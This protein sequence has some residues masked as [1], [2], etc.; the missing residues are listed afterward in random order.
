MIEPGIPAFDNLEGRVLRAGLGYPAVGRGLPGSTW[1][2]GNMFTDT[3][4]V[5][6][7]NMDDAVF[8]DTVWR[9]ED[10][11]H[12]RLRR[13]HPVMQELFY[14]NAMRRMQAIEQLTLPP[15]YTTIPNT[16]AFSRFEHMWGSALLVKQLAAQQG[17]NE[18]YTLWC[19][20]RTLNSDIKQTTGSHK[21][22]WMFQGIGGPE[23]LHDQGIE[24]YMEATG[25]TNILRKHGIEP[26]TIIFPKIA[27]WV[28]APSPDLCIDRVDY[29]LREM[30]RWNDTV[31]MLGFTASDFVLTPDL[32]LA[33]RDQQRAR[34]FSEGSLALTQ[35][36]YGE[37]THHFIEELEMLMTKL[38]YVERLAPDMWAFADHG[39]EGLVPLHEIHPHDL[40]YITDAAQT[41]FL[42]QPSL[43]GNTLD[44]LMTQIARYRRQYAW[45]ARR[46]RLNNYMDQF[47]DPESYAKVLE[48]GQ[49]V[50]IEDERHGSYLD[51]YPSSMPAG[52]AI[53]TPAEA[54]A[55]PSAQAIDFTLKPF[56]NR[57][58]D[59]L[60]Q[61]ND[62]FS[63]LSEL[64]PSYRD[65]LEEQAEV[66]S[67]DHV[68]RLAIPDPKTY[69]MIRE[70]MTSIE[71]A[72]QERIARSRRMTSSEMGALVD[73][74]AYEVHGHYPFMSFLDY[75]S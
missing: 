66:V 20:L 8:S 47:A 57:Q 69:R 44:A 45:P 60:V 31:R 30:N 61:T 35:E 64:D 26:D 65:R 10:N 53:L 5:P 14:S 9:G 13:E 4:F 7:C 11:G 25:L 12:L 50:G 34:V 42:R 22:D 73:A 16:A 32:M 33:M 1:E 75:S 49:Y 23:D 38:L 48:T 29:G 27:D 72:W 15:E 18:T 43:V 39:R 63:R 51:E 36:H 71:P 37:P 52:F 68:A 74:A 54:R 58:I 17:L 40:M 59:P 2:S 67:Q 21:G 24:G 55:N 46:R 62:G 6:N 19:M 41:K 56:K 28:E 70:F 3:T